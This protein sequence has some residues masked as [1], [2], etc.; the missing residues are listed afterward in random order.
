MFPCSNIFSVFEIGE[1]SIPGFS[2]ILLC[3]VI[4]NIFHY[5]VFYFCIHE[6]IHNLILNNKFKTKK[7]FQGYMY[8]LHNHCICFDSLYILAY[9]HTSEIES[10]NSVYC[11]ISMYFH[12]V[13]YHSYL[14]TENH[15]VKLY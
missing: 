2:Y 14:E 4:S 11:S 8:V 6:Q 13:Q 1:Y 3:T 10:R 7:K 12:N 9:I 5:T 15:Q